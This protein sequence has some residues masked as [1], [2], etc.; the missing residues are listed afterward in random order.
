MTFLRRL[1]RAITIGERVLLVCTLLSYLIFPIMVIVG[2]LIGDRR[3]AILPWVLSTALTGAL[4][5]SLRSPKGSG[6]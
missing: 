4:V 6:F 5:F 1:W 3:L 2:L